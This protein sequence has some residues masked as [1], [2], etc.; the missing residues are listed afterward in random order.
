MMEPCRIVAHLESAHPVAGISRVQAHCE[1]HGIDVDGSG[2]CSIGKIEE[3][4]EIA[5]AAIA[6]AKAAA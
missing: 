5:L 4:T 3:A 1:T 2:L 6:A